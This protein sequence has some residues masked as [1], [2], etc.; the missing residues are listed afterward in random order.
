M[1][2]LE[3][4]HREYYGFNASL[5]DNFEC[6]TITEDFVD[7]LYNELKPVTC[8]ECKHFENYSFLERVKCY[9]HNNTEGPNYFCA[10]AERK[11]EE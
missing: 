4:Y 11:I 10:D 3:E 9:K 7:W 5:P 6:P 8:G 1:K 2:N